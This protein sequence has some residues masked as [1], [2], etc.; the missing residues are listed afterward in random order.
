M[1]V[2]LSEIGQEKN[3]SGRKG[4]EAARAS[5]HTADVPVLSPKKATCQAFV[6]SEL[7]FETPV[8]S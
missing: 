6:P 1:D 2:L 3:S 7:P 5:V 4:R 8:R